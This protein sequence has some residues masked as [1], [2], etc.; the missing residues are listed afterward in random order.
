MRDNKI[1]R[2]IC[3]GDLQ[4]CLGRVFFLVGYMTP[5]WADNS[6]DKCSW[7]G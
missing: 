4:N 5:V 2:G 6:T 7:V 3:I 1:I